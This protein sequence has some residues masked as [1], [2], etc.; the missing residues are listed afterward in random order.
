MEILT[1]CE[2]ESIRMDS[3]PRRMLVMLLRHDAKRA[4][5]FHAMIREADGV[6]AATNELMLLHVDKSG[7]PRAAPFRPEILARLEAIAASHAALPA[8]R[9]AGRTIGFR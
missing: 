4:Q 5:L 2:H 8:P 3:T 7:A 9:Y 6:L 1:Y